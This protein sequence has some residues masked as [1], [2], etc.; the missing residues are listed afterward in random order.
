MSLLS[1]WF[2]S[3]LYFKLFCISVHMFS[4]ISLQKVSTS[5][6]T[7]YYTKLRLHNFI[8][9]L[10][11]WNK[12][13]FCFGGAYHLHL[14]GSTVMLVTTC[15]TTWHHNPEDYSWHLPCC[16]NLTFYVSLPVFCKLI[17]SL[18]NAL[19]VNYISET[20]V[21][22]LQSPACIYWNP[23]RILFHMRRHL[24]TSFH[25][26]EIHLFKMNES[27]IIQVKIIIILRI[28]RVSAIFIL[29]N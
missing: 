16:K 4:Y 12:V 25:R 6:F 27:C 3:H 5:V 18:I 26:T 28:L 13:R 14:Q 22:E 8:C 20:S 17:L 15:K 23:L 10:I 1:N 11:V 24:K 2:F 9:L 21:V 7:L 29:I 19:V